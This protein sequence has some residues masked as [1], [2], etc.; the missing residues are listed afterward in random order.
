MKRCSFILI[1]V[2]LIL[3]F[4]GCATP[5]SARK[6]PDWVLNP[7]LKYSSARYLTAVGTGD[8]LRAA[9][10]QAFN[11][12]A[13]RFKTRVQA[14]ERVSDA[15]AETFGSSRSFDKT[16]EYLSD[17][18]LETDATLLNVETLE[19]HRDATGHVY[20]LIALN[21]LETANVY[22]QKIADNA[23]RIVHLTPPDSD[24]LVVYARARQALILGLKNQQLVD[25]LAI[26]HG[27]SDA[28]MNRS[29][30]LAN[31]HV[32]VAE[33]TRAIRFNVHMRGDLAES[34]GR[35]VASV[36]TQRGFSENA[37]GH[38]QIFGSVT[39]QD[40]EFL[41]KDLSTVRYCLV[42]NLQDAQG[43]TVI[44]LQKE[45]RESHLSKEEVHRRVERTVNQLITQELNAR[46][47][48]LLSSMT[49]E[50]S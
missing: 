34:F 42:L 44:S 50:E 9:E 15:T 6:L 12:L 26:I 19:Q 28:V 41:R 7:D 10:G 32:R 33:S 29:Y 18:Q 47:N 31:L 39:I 37:V 25:Q 49:G 35:Q 2:A 22:E 20:A 23:R 48:A 16:S 30:S 5:P 43:K 11:R 36:M 14:S 27:G 3:F 4:S 21:R 45:G 1:A 40:M 17:I 8:T 24:K 46:L 13:G 38:L